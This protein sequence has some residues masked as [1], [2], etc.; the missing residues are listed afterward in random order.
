[1]KGKKNSSKVPSIFPEILKMSNDSWA[2]GTYSP[3]CLCYC[4]LESKAKR[5]KEPGRPCTGHLLGTE[6]C[7]RLPGELWEGC[8]GLAGRSDPGQR[9]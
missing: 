5:K 9:R 8:G 7:C 6:V 1:M 2:G 4:L 3:Y